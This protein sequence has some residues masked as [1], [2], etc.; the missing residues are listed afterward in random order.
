MPVYNGARLLP[1]ALDTLLAQTHAD[2]EL[3]I[4]DNA[5][6]DDTPAICAAYARR[7]RRIRYTRNPQN[8]GGARNLWHVLGLAAHELFMWAAHDDLWHPEYLKT[9]VE[10]MARRDHIVLCGTTAMLISSA[11]AELGPYRDED[12]NTGGLAKLARIAH[13]L[14]ELKRNCLFY[15]LHRRSV[16]RRL[17]VQTYYGFDHVWMAQLATF[18]EFVQRPECYFYSR[19]DGEGSSA[20]VYNANPGT[21]SPLFRYFPNLGLAFHF[22][23]AVAD[24]PELT[25]AERRQVRR[26]VLRRFASAPYPQR[27]LLDLALAPRRMRR[28]FLSRRAR[29]P[30]RSNEGST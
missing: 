8:I 16:I 25:A 4:A 22:Y 2:F 18:G 17:P 26:L 11:G 23:Q 9:C 29:L 15:G 13:V 7:D 19:L 14:A 3:V 20:D 27:M 5:S 30:Y 12:M 21:G 6:T 10:E 28:A 24:W 1:I